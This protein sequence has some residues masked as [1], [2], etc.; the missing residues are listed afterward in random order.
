[1]GLANFK[2]IAPNEMSSSNDINQFR[3]VILHETSHCISTGL[4][5]SFRMF[6]ESANVETCGQLIALFRRVSS[7]FICTL[8]F[9]NRTA[10]FATSQV[11]MINHSSKTHVLIYITIK[12]HTWPGRG[13][14]VNLRRAKIAD[15]ASS[16]FYSKSNPAL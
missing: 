10:I 9:G 13:S 4:S 3:R 2:N 5:E 11:I 15:D 14:Y 16:S 8:G 7:G 6:L 1:M 12:R